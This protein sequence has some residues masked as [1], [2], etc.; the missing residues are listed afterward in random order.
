MSKSNII[1][2]TLDTVV[3]VIEAATSYVTYEYEKSITQEIEQQFNLKKEA[4]DSLVEEQKKMALLEVEEKRKKLEMQLLVDK[5]HFE[6]EREKLRSIAEVERLRLENDHH[7]FMKYLDLQNQIR[8]PV[9]RLL[10][11]IAAMIEDAQLKH[12][13]FVYLNEMEETRR[14]ALS[15]YNQMINLLVSPQNDLN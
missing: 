8:D 5:K 4:L 13:D 14:E 10:N 15:R 12:Y 3:S 6:S 9:Q 7:E 11:F 1:M 2:L